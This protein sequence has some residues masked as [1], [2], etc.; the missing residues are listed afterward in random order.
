MS[1]LDYTPTPLS[2]VRALPTLRSPL[3]PAAQGASSPHPAVVSYL[4]GGS[5]LRQSY[6][7]LLAHPAPLPGM[8]VAPDVGGLPGPTVPGPATDP[9][10][11]T[12][13]SAMDTG[14]LGGGGVGPTSVSYMDDPILQK[15]IAARD[16]AL[17]TTR[18][19]AVGDYED[20]LL[21]FGSQQ[22][23][24]DFLGKLLSNPDYASA[25][26]VGAAS[27]GK[28]P[29][30]IESLIGG[31]SDNP[32][33]SQSTL[34]RISRALREATRQ[35]DSNLN[36]A[37]LFFS[38]TRGRALRDLNYENQGQVS[39][40]TQALQQALTGITRGVTGAEQSWQMQMLSAEEAAYMR[41]LQS[42]LASAGGA[43]GVG[44]GI[45]MPPAPPGTSAMP[46][47]P[48]ANP[49]VAGKSAFGTLDPA[50]AAWMIAHGYPVPH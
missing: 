4:A 48:N 14:G 35:T 10:V 16:A 30:A 32:D 38:G 27:G 25:A 7:S 31:I 45:A 36:G 11:V 5:P 26:G 3:N 49:A 37:N 2:Q 33:T 46:P 9:G 39:D 17:K 44:T 41:A 43:S 8:R 47:A 19:N 29:S 6:S 18:G 42:A 50:I 34:G 1:F 21:G 22:I 28:L 15:M 12:P 24:H 40:A 20:L 23:A 13:G